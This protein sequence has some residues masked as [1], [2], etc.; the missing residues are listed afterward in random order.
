M[1]YSLRLRGVKGAGTDTKL[2]LRVIVAILQI[3][4]ILLMLLIQ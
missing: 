4:A 2:I 3:T 1:Y